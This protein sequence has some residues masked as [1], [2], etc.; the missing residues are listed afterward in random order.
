[1]VST[2]NHG[3]GIGPDAVDV[4]VPVYKGR[5]ETLR[6]LY[7]VLAASCSTSFELIVIN[8]ASPDEQLVK[9]LQRLA[10]QGL[11]HVAGKFAESRLCPYC[12]S[13]HGLH[14]DRDVVL[15][16]ADTEVFDGWLD[17]LQQAAS[18]H[19]RTG[20]VTPLSNNATICSY[21]RFL[22][23]NPFPA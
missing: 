21:P 13:W 20:T 2:K 17:R 11:V 18:R 7:S 5:A 23:D 8:D 9:E 19:P 6:C 4:I 10:G 15:L 14:Q 16:N 3:V 22:Q 12:Q 1:M